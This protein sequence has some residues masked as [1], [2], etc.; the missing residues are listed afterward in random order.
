MLRS[1][2]AQR[3]ARGGGDSQTSV[4]TNLQTIL[5]ATDGSPAS[6][7]AVEFA[8]ELASEHQSAL[9]VVHVVPTV[10]LA[11][12]ITIGDVGAAFPHEPTAHD[13]AVLE[14]AAAFASEHGVAA[15]TA[16][17]S[18]LTVEKIVAYAESHDVDMIVVGSRGHGAIF[19]ALLGSVSLGVL[20]SSKRPVLIVRGKS[21]SVR[22]RV[23]ARRGLHGDAASA[24][25]GR[26]TD[27]RL[28]LRCHWKQGRSVTA[29]RREVPC[30]S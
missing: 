23:K 29:G 3:I 12:A 30:V 24:I 16:L 4:G 19:S 9:H 13:Y 25:V 27:R 21:R 17:L 14:A 8:V 11:P 1:D 18:G 28:L 22:T 20:R 15:M 7:E 10:D 6:Q 2:M 5:V 26:S